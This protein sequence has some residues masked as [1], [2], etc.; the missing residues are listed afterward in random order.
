[1]LRALVHQC[2]ACSVDTAVNV[3]ASEG[4]QRTWVRLKQAWS[5]YNAAARPSPATLARGTGE[6]VMLE[7]LIRNLLAAVDADRLQPMLTAQC[8]AMWA[9]EASLVLLAIDHHL[10]KPTPD[11]VCTSAAAC[12]WRT[13]S[14]HR[15]RCLAHGRRRQRWWRARPV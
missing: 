11:S 2:V 1:M 10:R 15:V 6:E 12:P 7:P 4:F 5:E 13:E 3:D 9:E 14:R 8:A